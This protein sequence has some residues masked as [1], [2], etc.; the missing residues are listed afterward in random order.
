MVRPELAGLSV[1]GDR[2][3][4]EGKCFVGVR[5]VVVAVGN[6]RSGGADITCV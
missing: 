6:I 1:P 4:L 2:D 5:S 3:T